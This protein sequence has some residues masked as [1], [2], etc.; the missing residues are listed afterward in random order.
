M[1]QAVLL[2]AGRA[3]KKRQRTMEEQIAYLSHKYGAVIYPIHCPQMDVSSEGIRSAVAAGLPI[4][5]LVPEPVEEYI[6][7]HGL[8]IHPVQ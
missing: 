5:G 6:R 8:Y 3:Y 4:S 7:S 2:V 1:G